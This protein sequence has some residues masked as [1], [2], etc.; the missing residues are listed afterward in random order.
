MKRLREYP[1]YDYDF[2]EIKTYC[3]ALP[4]REHQLT[5]LEY[6][7][8]RH[9]R[10]VE[11]YKD[12][13]WRHLGRGFGGAAAS[14]A[15]RFAEQI[16][17]EIIIR[18]EHEDVVNIARIKS[19]YE[20][21]IEWAIARQDLDTPIIRRLSSE[22]GFW[23]ARE[24]AEFLGLTEK[25]L[26]SGVAG[27]WVLPCVHLGRSV[28]WRPEDVVALRVLPMRRPPGRKPGTIKE[29]KKHA[30]SILTNVK[31]ELAKRLPKGRPSNE[32]AIAAALK[33]AMS[34]RNLRR[35]LRTLPI[36]FPEVRK[37]VLSS[38]RKK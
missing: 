32:K 29:E 16:E 21:A 19:H 30:E 35:I 3:E 36:T 8:K 25:A 20:V 23:N 13:V 7:A 15:Q 6:I 5:Y 17:S 28:R 24:V 1:I 38:L 27:T 18:S 37:Q 2:S 33:P 31:A 22:A 12:H 11:H 34:D 4:T 14:I 26:R 10:D 9:R